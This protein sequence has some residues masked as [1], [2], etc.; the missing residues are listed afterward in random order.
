MKAFLS[1]SSKDKAFVR[2]VAELLGTAQC[3]YDEY[4]FDHTLNVE[5][6]RAALRRSSLF[7]LFLSDNSMNSSFIAEE[8]RAALEN[9]GRGLTKQI[10]IIALDNTSYR[11]LPLWLQDINI[12]YKLTGPSAA[13]NKIQAGLLQL[14]IE[15]S[16]APT[17]Y[18]GR[19]EDEK[20]IRRALAAP[21][22]V[23]PTSLH[24]VGHRGVGRRTLLTR[25]LTAL[26]PGAIEAYIQIS[27]GRYDGLDELYRQLHDHHRVCSVL[28]RAHQFQTFSRLS[29]QEKLDAVYAIVDAMADAGEMILFIDD[30]GVY[31]DSGRYQAHFSA[32]T[33]RY[34]SYIQPVFSFI[35]TRMMSFA[36]RQDHP[37]SFHLHVRPLDS[38]SSKE[39]LSFSLKAAGIDFSAEELNLLSELTDGHPFNIH[40]VTKFAL[41][42]G[43][44]SLLADPHDLIEWKYKRAEDF[45]RQVSFSETECDIIVALTEYRLLPLESLARVISVDLPAISKATRKL[46]DFCC[47]D[48]RDGYFQVS[49]PIKEAIR[50][51]KRFDRSDIWKREL[52]N[53]ICDLADEY[54]DD[55]DISVSLIDTA[56]VAAIRGSKPTRFISNF[57][58]PSHYLL[59]AREYYDSKKS[60][61]CMEFCEKAFDMR[62]NLTLDAQI[63]VLR[64]WGLSA[65]RSQNDLAFSRVMAAIGEYTHI[66]ARRVS[67]FLK[68]FRHRVRGELDEAEP[69]FLEA[70]KLSKDNQSINR[71]IAGLYV[72]QKRYNE[73]DSYARAAYRQSPTN[74]Y[75]IDMMAEIVLGR[76]HDGLRIDHEELARLMSELKIYG[77][78]PGSSFFL[79][80]TAHDFLRRRQFPQARRE[81]DRAIERTSN[82]LPAYFIRV[83]VCLAQGDIPAAER[84][85]A[86]INDMLGERGGFSE[87]EE[88][89]LK[90]LEVKVLIEKKQYKAA[91]DIISRSILIP[92]KVARRLERQLATAIAY[93]SDPIDPQTA[94]WAKGIKPEPK[95]PSGGRR[96]S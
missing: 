81:I 4:T 20:T 47:I 7:V 18:V 60:K 25:A 82:L 63:E 85:I 39:L 91:I 28:D 64:L 48:L 71:E 90:E 30:G 83:E 41:E 6:I 5:A 40:F 29:P 36:S 89:Q 69:M 84:D 66:S 38:D 78:A 8:L 24:M 34:S 44:P 32:I 43:I 58:L 49:P 42:Y 73:A 52:G 92:H 2:R 35:Q 3:E 23:A 65:V 37:H 72:K 79:I 56:I 46:E 22:G 16:R 61:S 19:E 93:S 17:I 31:D 67:W 33:R 75:L 11:S 57:V 45:I 15:G 76:A 87:G 10:L 55:D 74:P 1:H 86:K 95:R 51:D 21:P 62:A 53:R 9:R 77:D 80:R 59:I 54:T 94:K 88:A 50:R 96:R 27:V 68:G 26:F 14:D 12:V 70:W 13:A